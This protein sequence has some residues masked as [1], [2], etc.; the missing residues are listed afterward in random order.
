[1]KNFSFDEICCLLDI[2]PNWYRVS[3][4]LIVE[5]FNY[6]SHYLGQED[7]KKYLISKNIVL[8]CCH[9]LFYIMLGKFLKNIDDN[10]DG[11]LATKT[12]LLHRFSNLDPDILAEIFILGQLKQNGCEL[13]YY[14]HLGEKDPE[15][16]VSFDGIEYAIEVTKVHWVDINGDNKKMEIGSQKIK[17][18]F[19]Q[20]SHEFARFANKTIIIRPNTSFQKF[21]DASLDVES[22]K[23]FF[24]TPNE[25]V[26]II[27]GINECPGL[28]GY[29]CHV[30][31]KPFRICVVSYMG[32]IYSKVWE[33][34]KEQYKN[35][36]L[37]FL[38]FIDVTR[39]SH[40][41][42]DSGFLIE[43][44]NALVD[45]PKCAGVMLFERDCVGEKATQNDIF[46]SCFFIANGKATNPLT[47]R[48][49]E[50]YNFANIDK[51]ILS[52]KNHFILTKDKND[53]LISK[54]P[55]PLNE[56]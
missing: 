7:P 36:P 26:Q 48:Q 2:T 5:Y 43:V 29:D 49:N 51:C 46:S 52:R 14:P 12:S 31:G 32:A 16:I 54:R 56:I 10:Y 28:Y 34:A 42:Y 50:Q 45:H 11:P 35:S 1:M 6:F 25:E 40:Y 53:L 3:Q 20:Y 4:E 47:S 13:R 21:V 27:D 22:F 55:F 19:E 41:S 33:K 9:G 30:G 23:K 39:S 38:L 44:R 24:L 17:Q 18:L 8:G 37:N 15:G